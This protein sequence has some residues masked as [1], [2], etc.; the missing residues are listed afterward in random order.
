MCRSR[1]KCE[2]NSSKH[3]QSLKVGP[4][5]DPASDIGALIDAASRDAVQTTVERACDLADRVLLRG[6]SSGPGAFLSPTLVEHGEPHAFFCQDEIFGPF[7]TLETFETE[8]EAVE[9]ADNTVFGPVRERVDPRL[10]SGFPDCACA[11]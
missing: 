7:V 4:G 5:I 8:K 10:G 2:T 1:T 6:T 3:S 9:K 11:A